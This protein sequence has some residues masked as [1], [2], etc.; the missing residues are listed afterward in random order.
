MAAKDA[1]ETALFMVSLSGS[2]SIDNGLG[3]NT[4]SVAPSL[5]HAFDNVEPLLFIGDKGGGGGVQNK[6]GKNIPSNE[7]MWGSNVVRLKEAP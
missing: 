3:P 4:D 6:R 7:P 2:P 5:P 1:W